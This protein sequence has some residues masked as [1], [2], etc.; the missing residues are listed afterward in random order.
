[1]VTLSTDTYVSNIGATHVVESLLNEVGYDA[2]VVETDVGVQFTGLAD[3]SFDAS[4]GLWLLPQQESYWSE[5]RDDVEKMSVVQEE[6]ELAL[7]VPYYMDDTNSIEDLVDNKNGIGE[8]LDWQITGI[9]PGA[10]MMEI[11]ENDVMPGYGLDEDW[12]LQS[13]SGAVMAT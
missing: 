7:P 12:D 13:S 4:V 11:T 3:G 5:D 1:K 2:E 10:G 6:V 8:D 9:S